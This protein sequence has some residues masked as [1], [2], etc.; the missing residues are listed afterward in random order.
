MKQFDVFISY[1]SADE[2]QASAIKD[3]L[4]AQGVQ[5]W[6]AP[7]SIEPGDDYSS[8]IP[9]AIDSSNILILLV[10]YNSQRSVWVPKEL[11][12]A[13]SHR[14]KVIPYKIIPCELMK[15]FSFYLTDVQ[16]IEYNND[17]EK[18]YKKLN[19]T[20]NYTLK[21]ENNTT[22]EF[23]TLISNRKT[24]TWKNRAPYAVFNSIIDNPEI[25][26]EREF[27]RIKEINSEKETAYSRQ[28]K[29]KKGHT[30]EVF[31][32]YHNNADPNT[33]AKKAIGIA[34]GSAIRSSF[35][36]L[37]KADEPNSISATIIAG[38]TNPL[39]VSDS[40]NITS[41]ED[42]YLKYV[43]GTAIIHNKGALNG[44]S[45]GPDYL[46]GVGSLIGFNKISG[47]LPGG[48]EYAGFIT[49]RF[50][51]DNAKE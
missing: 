37:I 5:C 24:F 38:D 3:Y 26:D 32:Y 7:E 25:G 49:Y 45:P 51:V 16:I 41:D 31:I 27:V 35:P 39:E 21:T 12:Y 14:K 11:S 17:I 1:S 13:L 42:C 40:I 22:K 50:F 9:D 28:I 47:L 46:F 33:I 48:E 29:I 43:P 10:S 4:S 23:P 15:S 44:Q 19:N 6:M 34:D 2:N 30:Y 20:I 36:K 8:V 18:T